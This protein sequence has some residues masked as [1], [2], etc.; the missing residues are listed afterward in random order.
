[1]NQRNKG[2]LMMKKYFKTLLYLAVFVFLAQFAFAYNVVKLSPEYFP[3][4]SIGRALSSAYIYVGEPDLDPTVVA[5][6]KT[7]S[8]QQEDG[9]IVAVAQPI[10]TGAGGV[11]LYLGSPVTLLVD[12][13]YSL[14]V[15]DSNESQ[16]YYV[17]SVLYYT[18]ITTPYA[19][20]FPDYTEVDQ[21]AIGGGNSIFD[22]LA[23][24]GAVTKATMYFAHNSGAATTTYTLTTNETITSNFDIIIEDGALIALT[25]DL[26][27]EG[28]LN[29]GNYQ[30]FSGAGA[31]TF[32]SGTQV[33]SA[34][35]SDLTV[36]LTSLGA[37]QKI[38]LMLTEDGTITDSPTVGKNITW[39]AGPDCVV[40][41]GAAKT[42]TIDGLIDID[43]QPWIG[44][45]VTLATS[46]DGL[47]RFAYPAWWGENT[48]PGTTDMTTEI[49]AAIDFSETGVTSYK[50]APAVL[51]ASH[52]YFV[53]ATLTVTASGVGLNCLDGTAF[54]VRSGNYGETLH[55]NP[56]GVA[57]IFFNY[58]RNIH[59]YQVTTPPIA[60]DWHV[61]FENCN[62]FE[63]VNCRLIDAFI[64]LYIDGSSNWVVDRCYFEDQ[65]LLGAYTA[66]TSHILINDN[67]ASPVPTPSSGKISNCELISSAAI[68]AAR[69][70]SIGLAIYA[71]D[72]LWVDNTHI[73]RTGNI[74]VQMIPATGD[75]QISSIFFDTCYIDSQG[76]GDADKGFGVYINGTSTDSL[77]NIKFNNCTI[78]D[79]LS[80]GNSLDGISF[81]DTADFNHVSISNSTIASWGRHGIYLKSA[82]TTDLKIN[83]NFIF[84]N[85]VGANGAAGI[86]MVTGAD[87]MSITNNSIGSEQ[88][89][90]N[91]Q[92]VP[93]NFQG[94]LTDS[95]VVGN[96]C[97]GN[98]DDSIAYAGAITRCLTTA[99]DAATL[100]EEE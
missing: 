87:H 26:I 65:A 85:D 9:T 13:D 23:E 99:T 63:I 41:A 36:A 28:S 16:I 52:G 50:T 27:I 12:G 76:N 21:G 4:T 60:G 7:L 97:K 54:L 8:V 2:K 72:G 100:N 77:I 18:P 92:N 30:V 73:F 93:I 42:L 56:A 17:P 86:T 91:L 55:F 19:R 34:W 10:R 66:N 84:G 14:T 32:P 25:G 6:Q 53:S 24:V 68:R 79:A 75:E 1:M 46:A 94:T 70:Y 89:G 61:R 45:N 98:L 20:Y 3:N 40:S 49:Q 62:R 88:V 5:N 81:Q 11:P 57:F 59:F 90:N 67:A 96:L 78:L 22:I 83:N 31:V 48:A 29:A 82:A 80:D 44:A 15:L 38:T 51:L 64:N 71:I 69:Y 33:K 58:V 43:R 95:V 74:G 47:Q 35:Y 37:T 39:A